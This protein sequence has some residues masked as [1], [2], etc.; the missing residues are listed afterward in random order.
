MNEKDIAIIIPW[1]SQTKRIYA[2]NKLINW[3][4]ENY[5]N[6]EIIVSDSD[7]K[8]FSLSMARNL[9]A[10]K[11]ISEGYKILIFNDA[12]AFVEK[13]YLD[14]AIKNSIDNNEITVPYSIWI[15]SKSEKEN[16]MLFNK[17]YNINSF[18]EV[19]YRPIILDNKKINSLWPCS[20]SIVVPSNIYQKLKGFNEKISSWGPEDI[21][22]HKD[23]ISNYK[24]PFR[25]TKGLAYST[26]NYS[27]QRDTNSY[28]EI[29]S[30][31]NVFIEKY[32]FSNYVYAE[33]NKSIDV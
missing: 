11:A 32:I 2:F 30:K 27:D 4:K 31:L 8:N 20:S 29:R 17:N 24:K 26:Y 6:V 3:Y 22:F 1:R 13:K 7:S 19:F 23:Y 15:Q 21:L 25:Y 28:I 14:L 5:N 16:T 9:G 18:F 12:D 33:Y 10:K